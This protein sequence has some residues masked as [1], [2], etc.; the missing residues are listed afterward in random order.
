MIEKSGGEASSP[1][2]N[3]WLFNNNA[4]LAKAF[5]NVY[6]ASDY[7]NHPEHFV[8]GRLIDYEVWLQGYLLNGGEVSGLYPRDWAN[9]FEKELLYATH[10]FTLDDERGSAAR[11][12]IVM[13]GITQ[14][15]E[16]GHNSL[17]FLEDY[18]F[19]GNHEIPVFITSELKKLNS[20]IAPFFWKGYIDGLV[21]EQR[22][23]HVDELDE[24]DEPR[25]TTEDKYRQFAEILGIDFTAK[26]ILY[27][28]KQAR[29]LEQ[30]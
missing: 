9:Y 14:E 4:Q 25:E 20:L 7:F 18:C 30:R 13:P 17:Y 26:D 12:V 19:K 2:S 23:R 22:D 10:N 6:H 28:I 16:V 24:D 15:G 1:F 11:N 5:A 8:P 29:H 3:N 21:A 27:A